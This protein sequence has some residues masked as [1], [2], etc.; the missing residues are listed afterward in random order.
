MNWHESSGWAAEGW[1]LLTLG[2]GRWTWGVELVGGDDDD[3]DELGKA[4]GVHC[5]GL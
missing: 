3:D 2:E 5:I 4:Q 1:P